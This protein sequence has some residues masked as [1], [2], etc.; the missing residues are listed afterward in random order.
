MVSGVCMDGKIL[1]LSHILVAAPCNSSVQKRVSRHISDSLVR[2]D[3]DRLS[4][5]SC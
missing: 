3:A 4:S 1:H 2:V 5:S